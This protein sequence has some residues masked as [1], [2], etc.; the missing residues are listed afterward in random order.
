VK[1]SEPVSDTTLNGLHAIVTGG[2]RGIGAAIADVLAA[3]GARLT[4]MGRDLDALSARAVQ[5]RASHD[6]DAQAVQCD[7]SDSSHVARAFTSA[8]RE[9]GAAHIL[10]NNAGQAAGRPFA[11]TTHE[12]WERM[13]AVNLT[14]A[15]LCTRQVLPAMLR[16]GSG[17]IINIAS[18]SGLTGYRNTTAYCASKH[19]LIGLTRALA[20]EVARQ[21]ITVN[22]VCP[23]Y[24]DTEMAA[25]A[26]DDIVREM[27]KSATEAQK[28]LTRRNPLGRLITPAEVAG[29]VAWL[30][31]GEASAMTGQSI[32]VA[33]GELM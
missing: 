27:G 6:V 10:V 30:C 18:T 33:G 14:G 5:V 1:W 8:S 3:R 16:A 2:G 32:I 19:G 20:V 23:A 13:L 4:L 7:V 26:V 24:T 31:S 9:F 11:E 17:R 21:G 22:A 15:F 28:L 25:R 12:L 29:A